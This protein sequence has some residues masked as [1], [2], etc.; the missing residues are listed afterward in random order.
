MGKH[1]DEFFSFLLSKH[2]AYGKTEFTITDY[3]D[4]GDYQS[5]IQELY[6]RGFIEDYHDI[7][8]TIVFSDDVLKKLN[9]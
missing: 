2:K 8:G 7:L 3:M 9:S 6:N 4:F 1:G 5:A